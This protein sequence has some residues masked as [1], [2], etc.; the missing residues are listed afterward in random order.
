[1]ED[2]GQPSA[3]S[4]SGGDLVVIDGPGLLPAPRFFGDPSQLS[5]HGPSKV[6]QAVEGCRSS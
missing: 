3:L 2:M 4:A 6:S 5:R 1:V